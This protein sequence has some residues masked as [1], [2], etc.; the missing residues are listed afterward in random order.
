MENKRT[1]SNVPES[2]LEII[3]PE[4]S[5]RTTP[6]LFLSSARTF[7]SF[8]EK[9]AASQVVASLSLFSSSPLRSQIVLPVFLEKEEQLLRR[10]IVEGR[11]NRRMNAIRRERLLHELVTDLG[12]RHRYFLHSDRVNF[13]C[14]ERPEVYSLPL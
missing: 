4:R 9:S 2:S 14:N 13:L 11:S 1:G 5:E 7:V 8:H 3:L 6:S 10:W 12:G